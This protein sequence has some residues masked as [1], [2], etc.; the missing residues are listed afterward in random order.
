MKFKRFLALALSLLMVFGGAASIF[1]EDATTEAEEVT[2]ANPYQAAIDAL[3]VLGIFKGDD[4][5]DSAEKAVN[6][7]QMALFVSRAKTGQTDD[8]YWGKT[9]YD[10]SKFTD[11]TGTSSLYLGAIGYANQNGI[12]LGYDD[13]ATGKPIFNP[14]GGITY[15]DALTMATRTLGFTGL[16]YPWG[17]IEKAQDLGLTKGIVDVGYQD[18]LTRG[19]VAQIVYNMLIAKVLGAD[20]KYWTLKDKAFG[21]QEA[22]VVIVAGDQVRYDTDK[23]VLKRDNYVSFQILGDDG[24]V[25]DPVYSISATAFDIDKDEDPDAYV[26]YSYSVATSDEFA[27][28]VSCEP[29]PTVTYW[30][31]GKVAKN[32]EFTATKFNEG[33]TNEYTKLVIVNPDD[34]KDTTD[35]YSIVK[36]YTTLR[37][38]Q[39]AK[40][41]VE[42]I[43]GDSELLVYDPY[44]KTTIVT[45]EGALYYDALGNILE[46]KTD[47]WDATLGRYVTKLTIKYYY[48]SFTKSYF[49][50]TSDTTYNSDIYTGIYTYG[51][52]PVSDSE[53]A[54]AKVGRETTTAWSFG[55]LTALSNISSTYAYASL[56]LID[57]YRAYEGY[58]R[59]IYK[60]YGLGKIDLE[61]KHDGVLYTKVRIPTGLVGDLTDDMAYGA[62]NVKAETKVSF[63]DA[64]TG[65]AKDVKH[66][67]WVL[68]KYNGATNTVEVLDTLTV[69]KGTL[70]GWTI[71]GKTV[72]IGNEK[73]PA[74]YDTLLN[75]GVKYGSEAQYKDNSKYDFNTNNNNALYS[76][77]RLGVNYIVLDGDVV[78]IEKNATDTA[79]V[80]VLHS[81]L[82]ITSDGML[83]YYAY[84]TKNPGSL[85]KIKVNAINN[86]YFGSYANSSATLLSAYSNLF[87]NTAVKGSIYK[88]A[89]IDSDGVYYLSDASKVSRTLTFDTYYRAVFTE[90]GKDASVQVNGMDPAVRQITITADTYYVFVEIDE[91][92]KLTN[93]II[94]AKGNPKLNTTALAI[95]GNY[96]WA[97]DKMVVVVVDDDTYMDIV[98]Y[99][100]ST[101]NV[102]YYYYPATNAS[103]AITE[104]TA[105][106]ITY[107]GLINIATGES[108][109]V[110]TS[111][112]FALSA[113][114]TYR[115]EDGVIVQ[116]L[117]KNEL[118]W[119][120]VIAAYNSISNNTKYVYGGRL[121]FNSTPSASHN[122][123]ARYKNFRSD[124]RAA[125]TTTNSNIVAPTTSMLNL[126]RNGDFTVRTV[127]EKTGQISTNKNSHND[128]LPY[129]AVARSYTVDW[130]YNTATGAVAAYIVKDEAPPVVVPT[131]DVN[132]T[133]T[134]PAS[135]GGAKLTGLPIKLT[136][137]CTE[138]STIIT[139]KYVN[140]GNAFEDDT[141]ALA[142]ALLDGILLYKWTIGANGNG[143][144]VEVTGISLTQSTVV[145]SADGSTATVT[146]RTSNSSNVALGEGTYLL[147]SLNIRIGDL[148]AWGSNVNCSYHTYTGDVAT[149]TGVQFIVK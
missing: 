30:N 37:T 94:T 1:A 143:S 43:P 9:A 6:R 63:V 74:N 50:A 22:V 59:A 103:V 88:I 58:D 34:A 72:T 38:I 17:V 119:S 51:Y 97:T 39:G 101:V 25:T 48:N 118:T 102:A 19:E 109:Q 60:A 92:G 141:A 55:Q 47:S 66:G 4:N 108:G 12:I 83:E 116:N 41:G 127:D 130:F 95:T 120:T 67:D 91:S 54:A 75:N 29:N 139:W 131:Y 96:Y 71:P 44:A 149:S 122:D 65:K 80:V 73:F 52:V 84:T 100:D 85:Q 42:K 144:W 128:V 129:Y 35:N 142:S 40:T 82:G 32:T 57:D 33:K 134:Y 26:G 31:M 110:K 7:W 138:T 114:N 69:E 86:W 10:Y 140:T 126:I 105:A 79:G 13:P 137:V 76:L 123:D 11:V 135:S 113:G 36:E 62:V 61:T 14:D 15:Q 23:E 53:I 125:I 93:N 78:W 90:N 5:G 145:I 28:F 104:T 24:K 98:K 20:G 99:F 27:S 64:I 124:F 45:K 106:V 70:T 16:A 2:A 56:T 136:P 146:L 81:F 132:A 68:F 148:G 111:T 49:K 87:T 18:E 121:T 112:N 115:A 77:Y 117:G 8:A 147:T 21:I 46:V 89:A 133:Y 3:K 107:N